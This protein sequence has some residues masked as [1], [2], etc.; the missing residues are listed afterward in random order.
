MQEAIKEFQKFA[1]MY[2]LSNPNIMRKF[3]HTFRVV[4]YAKD[5]ARS[6]GLTEDDV[7]LA[8]LCALLHDIARF[9]QWSIYKTYED[10]KSYDHGEE[11]YKILKEKNYIA[12]YTTDPYE[13]RIILKAVKNHNKYKLEEG[14]SE[15][16]AFFAKI[17]RD[18]DKIDIICSQ[19]ELSGVFI[20]NPTYIKPFQEKRLFKNSGVTGQYEVLLRQIAF[21]YDMNFKYT[22]RLLLANDII[23][24]KIDLLISH[25][26]NIGILEYIKKTVIE[27]M[28]ER[29][30]EL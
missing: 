14:L 20:L 17:L 4:E 23:D 15:R 28:E 24:K 11:A 2:D 29:L 27:Y 22:Y 5:I 10:S 7:N 26:S 19:N 16:E 3:H 12:N 13:Q 21:V 8:M 6:E 30:K 25:C 18:A 9:R 1:K